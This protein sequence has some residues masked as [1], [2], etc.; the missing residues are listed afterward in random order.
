MAAPGRPRS[1]SGDRE[2]TQTSDRGHH[3]DQAAEERDQSDPAKD[4]PPDEEGDVP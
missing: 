3:P 4:Q 2:R 1:A